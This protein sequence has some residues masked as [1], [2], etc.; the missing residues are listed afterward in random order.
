VSLLGCVAAHVRACPHLRN[1]HHTSSLRDCNCNIKDAI[2]N[3]FVSVTT[4]GVEGPSLRS[5]VVRASANCRDLLRTAV[6]PLA[7]SLLGCVAAHVR[8]CPHLRNPHHT[9][10]LRDC[11]CN[12]KDAIVSAFFDCNCRGEGV[13]AP[14]ARCEEC[15]CNI[16]SKTSGLSQQVDW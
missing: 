12:I 2:V 10:S 1:P 9:S 15:V 4:R 16:T 6:G 13:D 3:A 5:G 7:V 11:N 8:A 14:S